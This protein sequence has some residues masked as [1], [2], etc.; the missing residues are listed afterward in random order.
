MVSPSSSMATY[1]PMLCAAFG[2]PFATKV[3]AASAA[4]AQ[5]PKAPG[6]TCT[7]TAP[8]QP[9]VQLH[10]HMPLT[11]TEP[12]LERATARTSWRKTGWLE[13]FSCGL[14]EASASSAQ[15]PP[16][17][18]YTITRPLCRPELEPTGSSGSKMPHALVMATA[19]VLPSPEMA[20]PSPKRK[21]AARVRVAVGLGPHVPLSRT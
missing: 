21:S 19:M 20:T 9:T 13:S 2:P 7:L 11:S 14:S 3:A 10:S 1:L 15:P 6:R 12:S 17:F 8:S 16:G 4:F 18:S 5:V